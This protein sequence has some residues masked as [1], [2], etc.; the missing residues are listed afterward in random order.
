[1]T[2]LTFNVTCGCNEKTGVLNV[3]FYVL[4]IVFL[5]NIQEMI[6]REFCSLIM[7]TR[8]LETLK[9]LLSI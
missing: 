9:Q 2:I 5:I 6:P 4:Y 8:K 1:M 3:N 7:A